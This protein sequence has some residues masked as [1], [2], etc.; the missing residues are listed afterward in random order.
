MIRAG[1][2]L[3]A[4]LPAPCPLEDLARA[5]RVALVVMREGR[6]RDDVVE[7]YRIRF[8]EGQPAGSEPNLGKSLRRI[9]QDPARVT[10]LA[11]APESKRALA[12]ETAA[13]KAAGIFGSPSFVVGGEVFRG[14]D[15]L[16]DAIA[17]HRHGRLG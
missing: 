13:A 17:W 15:R 16:E 9:G 10:G 3:P 2:G 4:R 14:D 5:N 1:Y 12:A 8:Q 11:D 6:C 7:T